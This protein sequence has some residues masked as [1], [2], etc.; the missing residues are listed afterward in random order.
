MKLEEIGFYTLSDE[1]ARNVSLTSPLQRCELLLTD[2]CNFKCPYCR[3][4]NEYTKGTLTFEQA[5]HII[6][7]WSSHHL[8]NV[9]FSGGEPTIVPYLVDLVKYSK[10]HGIQ[11][12][13][14]SSNGSASIDLYQK[15]LNAGANDFS[16]SL[17]ACCASTGDMMAGGIS[18]AWN[19][20]KES[21]EFLAQNTYVTVGVVLTDFNFN[22]LPKIIE[23]ASDLN[24]S[25]VRIISSAQWNNEEKFRNLFNNQEI[26][27]KYP[28]L[29]YRIENFRN[30]RNVRGIKSTDCHQCYLMIDDMVI[31]GNY[32]FPCVIA[33]REGCEPVGTIDNKTMEQIRKERLD[34]LMK[35]DTHKNNICSKNCLDVCVDYCNK[36]HN[37]HMKSRI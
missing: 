26:L 1:R 32:H 16:I 22:E 2:R 30:G 12:I 7:L 17:D 4:P 20:V 23:F 24:V 27:T 15:L 8:K 10:E 11:R 13:A 28:I 9:R 31:A 34:W 21:I 6:D 25:D 14:I 3:G 35:N 19:K 18:G 36:V 5:K 37:F 33:M 29:K